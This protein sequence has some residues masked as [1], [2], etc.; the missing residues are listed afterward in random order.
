MKMNG[1][2]RIP[3][4]K[5]FPSSTDETRRIVS[6]NQPN[7]FTGLLV[8]FSKK[9][10]FNDAK[11][12][13]IFYLVFL[14]ALAFLESLYEFDGT[15]FLVQKNNFVNQYGVK[16]GWF[17]T[18]AIVGPFIWFSSKAHN[19]KDSRD[20]PLIDIARLGVATACWYG[21]TNLFRYIHELTSHCT[22]GLS[23]S[24]Q[25]CEVEGGD[26]I[27]G[28]DFS[29]HCFLMLYSILVLTEEAS[30]FRN[31]QKVTD[32]VLP[33]NEDWEDHRKITRIINFF[34]VAM[35]VLHV[36]WFKQLMISVIYY[37]TWVEEFGG[38]LTAVACWYLTYRVLYPAGFLQSPIDRSKTSKRV[39]NVKRR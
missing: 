36:L 22:S 23:F 30:A 38:A 27:H 33:T 16:I 25:K 15:F 8:N 13:A 35:G 39:S 17:W 6:E 37:H 26:W 7:F 18:L 34:F 24:L 3:P 12:I 2:L 10:L 9:I 5:T 21:A 20:Q 31:Y 19:K 28:W 11:N 32:E 4:V 14:S 1:N 29:G